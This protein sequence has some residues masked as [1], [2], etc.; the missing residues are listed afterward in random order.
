MFFG[1]A[2]L[3]FFT[4]SITQQNTFIIVDAALWLT[5]I[6][7]VSIRYVDIKWSNGQTDDEY[8]ESTA[9]RNWRQYSL[10]LLLASGAL[11][12]LA[13]LAAHSQLS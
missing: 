5:V 7:L 9:L 3:I 1:I 2:F 13:R 4:I 6:M 8:A 11:Y 10:R 12:S